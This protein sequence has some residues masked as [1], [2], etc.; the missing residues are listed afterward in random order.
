MSLRFSVLLLAP[1]LAV[2]L[3]AAPAAAETVNCTQITTLPTTLTN[4]GVYCLKKDL[5]TS[6]ASGI[7]I[8]V[9]A[10]NIT[11]DC[12]G[13]KI[14]GLAAGPATLATG[15]GTNAKRVNAVL[16]GCSI[17]GFR[18][19]VNLQGDG[20]LVED[21][22]L[23]G[24]TSIGMLVWGDAS[25]IR[26]NRIYATGGGNAPWPTI[27]LYGNG[28]VDIAGNTVAGVATAAGLDEAAY[29]I[30]TYGNVE[31]AVAFNEV[32]GVVGGLDGSWAIR[33]DL[34]GSVSVR[35]N[36]VAAESSGY[37]GTG[38]SCSTASGAA[39]DN[40]ILGFIVHVAGCS[41]TDNLNL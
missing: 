32:R 36:V 34:S 13:F 38:I 27:G 35:G 39:T 9:A 12:N 21:N 37:S 5:V 22:R 41:S 28:S 17:R 6:I 25:T 14:G 7:A 30:F 26:H 4:Q 18:V 24:N 16:R 10:N 29:G 20:H 40:Q 19:G 3:H 23:D 2:A 15:V 33:N 11:I 31:G 1:C 8:T